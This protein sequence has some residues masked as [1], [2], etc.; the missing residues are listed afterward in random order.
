MLASEQGIQYNE[1]NTKRKGSSMGKKPVTK[2]T[3]IIFGVGSVFWIIY[4]ILELLFGVPDMLRLLRMVVAGVWV[5][6]FFGMAIRYRKQQKT[7]NEN[8]L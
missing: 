5:M 1:K 8:K 6:G 3:V 4:L 2:G 7:E